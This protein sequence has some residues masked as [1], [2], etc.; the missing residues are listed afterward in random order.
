MKKL[1]LII[2]IILG[3]I[4]SSH[5]IRSPWYSDTLD[6]TYDSAGIVNILIPIYKTVIDPA[7]LDSLNSELNAIY[8]TYN[9]VIA[10]EAYSN[11]DDY[12]FADNLVFYDLVT[13][14]LAVGHYWFVLEMVYDL[15]EDDDVRM[16]IL[17]DHEHYQKLIEEYKK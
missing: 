11:G 16:V 1:T 3:T 4:A 8:K 15:T 2:T 6:V 10:T 13:I 9:E 14:L 5:A 17:G 7:G 12:V